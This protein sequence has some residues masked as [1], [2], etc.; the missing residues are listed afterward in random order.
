MDILEAT[1]KQERIGETSVWIL[2]CNLINLMGFLN[3][4]M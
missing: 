4:L 3:E 1:F 2:V